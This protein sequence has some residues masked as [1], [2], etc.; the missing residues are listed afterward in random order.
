[1]PRVRKTGN[2]AR[3]EPSKLR[4]E[5][6]DGRC[7]RS[8][9]PSWRR[10]TSSVRAASDPRISS[11]EVLRSGIGDDA[12]R[13]RSLLVNNVPLYFVAPA[14]VRAARAKVTYISH[15]SPALNMSSAAS[16]AV[17]RR[18]SSVSTF[19]TRALPLAYTIMMSLPPTNSRRSGSREAGI[20][21]D[22]CLSINSLSS[23][24]REMTYC[25]MS[26]SDTKAIVPAFDVHRT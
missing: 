10:S 15:Q 3:S 6:A 16:N 2:S 18:N 20:R 9:A 7:C 4:G 5:A 13:D 14:S 26:S 21:N 17:D 11:I 1:M 22:L 19:H 23:V 25:S 8:Q 24:I 12:G